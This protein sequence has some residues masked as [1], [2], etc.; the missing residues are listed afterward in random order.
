MKFYFSSNQFAQLAAFDFHQRQEII[1][2]ASSRLSPLSKFI[3]NLLK[4]AVL[5][6][7]FFML[8]NIDSWLF[9]IPLAFVLLGYFIVLRPLS[10]LF[11][12][13][14]LDKS[15]EQFERETAVE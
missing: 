10:L 2:I 12:S 11:I 7:P 1:A 3:L 5:I 13:S 6:P 14:H 8:A 4:L 15:I 9:V